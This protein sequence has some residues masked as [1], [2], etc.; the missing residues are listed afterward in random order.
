VKA[1][2]PGL[3][4]SGV[5][6]NKPTEFTVDAKHGGKGTLRVQ[7]Q[8]GVGAGSHPHKVKVFGPGV[9]KT[10]LK[11]LEPTFFT[12][13]CAEAGQ[14]DVSIGIKCAPGVVGPAE[15]DLDFD[16]I[17]ND[18]DTFTVKYTPR[19]AGLH[20]IMVLFAGQ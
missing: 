8:V 14:G 7:M 4:A 11:A 16:I 1:Q 10:G 18:N 19:G 9:A 17:R 15:A 13:D 12:V 6:L 20:T 5:V 2:G 3:E